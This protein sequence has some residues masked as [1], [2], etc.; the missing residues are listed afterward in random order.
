MTLFSKDLHLESST[1]D[2]FVGECAI[3]CNLK[4]ALFFPELLATSSRG[5]FSILTCLT[6]IAMIFFL[7][8]IFSNY[9]VLSNPLWCWSWQPHPAIILLGGAAFWRWVL[10]SMLRDCRLL[11]FGPCAVRGVWLFTWLCVAPHLLLC[12][13]ASLVFWGDAGCPLSPTRSGTSE[14]TQ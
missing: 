7:H 11:L 13:G 8:I 6:V 5:P 14:C 9:L 1:L 3:H 12:V 2:L 4:E 10:R